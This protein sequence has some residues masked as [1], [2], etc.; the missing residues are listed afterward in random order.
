[1]VLRIVHDAVDVAN[2][3]RAQAGWQEQRGTQEHA[4]NR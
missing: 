4:R 3:G 2:I 1:M